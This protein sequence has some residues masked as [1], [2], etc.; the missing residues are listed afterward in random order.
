MAQPRLSW[1]ELHLRADELQQVRE[2]ALAY[3]HVFS[4]SGNRDV[5]TKKLHET[6]TAINAIY[7]ADT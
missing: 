2:L 3:I 5:I 6:W 7:E 4:T 1:E